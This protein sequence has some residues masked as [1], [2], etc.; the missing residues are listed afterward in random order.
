MAKLSEIYKAIG[1][2][3]VAHGDREVTSVATWCG[4]VPEEF[5]FNLKGHNGE[6][7]DILRRR[8]EEWDH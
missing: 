6:K 3:L 7:I 5:T 8:D 2:Y 4:S 1:E